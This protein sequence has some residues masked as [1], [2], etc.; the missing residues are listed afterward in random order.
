MLMALA[1][2]EDDTC[3]QNTVSGLNVVVANSGKDAK[4]DLDALNQDS[5]VGWMITAVGDTLS[6]VGSDNATYSSGIPLNLDDTTITVLFKIKDTA[7]DEYLVDTL[8]FDYHQTDLVL[9]S[10]QCGFAPLFELTGGSYTKSVLDSVVVRAVEVS[11][12]LTINNVSIYY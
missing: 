1:C 3:N 5:I 9:L 2:V 11:T 7:H 12:D 6:F 10:V 4:T 8:V